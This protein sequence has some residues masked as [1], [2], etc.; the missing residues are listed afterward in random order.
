MK[1]YFLLIIL[2]TFTCNASVFA[3]T[4]IPSFTL[5]ELIALACNNDEYFDNFVIN[6][7]FV[8]NKARKVEDCE[9]CA[10]VCNMFL[11]AYGFY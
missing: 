10:F 1:K 3:Q 9:G 6:T 7:R 5:T 11:K 8:F 2:I 4:I